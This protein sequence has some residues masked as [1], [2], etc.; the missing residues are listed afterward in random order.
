[1]IFVAFFEF[2][3]VFSQKNLKFMNLR[4]NI[5]HKMARNCHKKISVNPNLNISNS[6]AVKNN[7][8]H[9]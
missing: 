4:K 2:F 8:N 9:L 7:K 5:S 3:V 1:V 6:C